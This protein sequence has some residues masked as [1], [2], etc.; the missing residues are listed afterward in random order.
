M[1]RSA[2]WPTRRARCGRAPGSRTG[3]GRPWPP[4]ASSCSSSP[5][6]GCVGA[7]WPRSRPSGSTWRAAGSRWPSLSSRSTVCWPGASRRGTNAGRCPSRP[8]SPTSCAGTWPTG[9][10][11]TC[12]HRSARRGSAAQPD[13]PP[14][15]LRPG[16]RSSGPGRPGAARAPAHG[17]GLAVSSGAN[18]KSVQRMLGHASA[19]LTLDTYADL[20][21]DDLDAVAE[22]LDQAARAVREV[23]ADSLRTARRVEAGQPSRP[24]GSR[25]ADQRFRGVP[26]A[27]FE[28]AL[29]PPEGGALSPELRGL[30][31][32]TRLPVHGKAPAAAAPR[33]RSRG[34]RIAGQGA[35][36]G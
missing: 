21:D 16:R 18:V 23:A 19:A 35:R 24:R 25:V 10:R 17:R 11:T 32:P 2:A 7:N 31:T 13:L 29:P 4:T 22:R 14:R 36:R 15:R 27:G 26:P 5:T 34:D 9:S 3:S 33:L 28:P 12:F 8:S 6:A 20:F 1:L 30:G